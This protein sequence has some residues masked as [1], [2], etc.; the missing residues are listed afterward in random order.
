MVKAFQES[1]FSTDFLLKYDRCGTV[2][3]FLVT[4]LTDNEKVIM[5]AHNAASWGYYDTIKKSWNIPILR[6]NGF[7]VDLLPEVVDAGT[8]AGLLVD[9]WFGVPQGTPVTASMG[10][11][12]VISVTPYSTKRDK[13]QRN[14]D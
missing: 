1:F 3:D 12:Q 11:L 13:C 5:S 8:D 10:D 7:P 2:M 14:F 9:K 4:M 6:E